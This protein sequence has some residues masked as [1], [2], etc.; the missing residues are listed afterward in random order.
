VLRIRAFEDR[1]EEAVI[2]LWHRCGLLRPWNDPRKDID[3]KR[4]IQR[5]LFLVAVD[6][7]PVRPDGDDA[8][9]VGTVMAGYDGHRGWINYLGVDPACQRRGVGR[10]LM[11]EVESRLRAA[12]CP[13]INLQIRRDNGAARAFYERIGWT[14][15]AVISLGKRLERDD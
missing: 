9:I 13:K 12:G 4:R 14:E 6:H 11:D 10:A 1:D 8:P 5:D 15:D 2:A 7:G 3:R